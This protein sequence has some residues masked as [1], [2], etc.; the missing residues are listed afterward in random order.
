MLTGELPGSLDPQGINSPIQKPAPDGIFSVRSFYNLLNGGGIRSP[1]YRFIW[2]YP[3][4]MKVKNFLRLLLRTYERC[5][6]LSLSYG[7]SKF[8]FLRWRRL[9]AHF[10]NQFGDLFYKSKTP[11]LHHLPLRV[12]S[13]GVCSELHRICSLLGMQSLLHSFGNWAYCLRAKFP[14]LQECGCA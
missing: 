8:I 10:L 2:N 5:F 4:P 12:R 3:I 13:P 14:N 9:R 1:R 11:G 6:T 7:D